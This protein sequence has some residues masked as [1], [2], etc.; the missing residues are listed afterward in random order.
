LMIYWTDIARLDLD[1]TETVNNATSG[2]QAAAHTMKT[3][4][5]VEKG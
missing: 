4:L 3:L 5:A 1:P 2:C